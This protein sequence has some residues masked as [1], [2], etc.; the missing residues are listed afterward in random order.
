MLKVIGFVIL[1][2]LI[3]VGY[4]YFFDHG[5][6]RNIGLGSL[7]A[8]DDAAQAAAAAPPP[9]AGPQQQDSGGLVKCV[10]SRGNITFSDHPCPLGQKSHAVQLSETQIVHLGPEAAS[11]PTQGGQS[12]GHSQTVTNTND[13]HKQSTQGAL[14][15]KFGPN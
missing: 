11:A 13:D 10:D 3:V 5:L 15:Q 12:G 8:A 2:V 9:D 4:G 14:F 7:V 6:L 1:L